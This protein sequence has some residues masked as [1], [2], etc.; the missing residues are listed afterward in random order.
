M[1]LSIKLSNHNVANR[2]PV[3][4]FTVLKFVANR[5]WRKTHALDVRQEPFNLG[6][7]SRSRIHDDLRT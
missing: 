6:H 5:S 1:T 2:T 7:S 4:T 3:T